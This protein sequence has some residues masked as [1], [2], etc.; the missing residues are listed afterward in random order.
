MA[1]ATLRE[2]NRSREGT[3]KSLNFKRVFCKGCKH[4]RS[5]GQFSHSMEFCD[6]CYQRLPKP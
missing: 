3:V 4:H 5:I 6:R 1:T 2:Q